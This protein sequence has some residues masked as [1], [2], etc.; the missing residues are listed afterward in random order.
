MKPAAP[1][2][3]QQPKFTKPEE[4]A[5]AKATIE[6]I[7]KVVRDPQ[8]APSPKAL[9]S[10]EVQKRLVEAVKDKLSGGQIT[11]YPDLSKLT[12]DKHECE[13]TDEPEGVSVLHT[14]KMDVRP[15]G[16]SVV[17]STISL[18]KP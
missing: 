3:A 4:V 2:P 9:Q 6:A 5:A 7:A 8:I 10:D 13:Q 11:L 15:K 18:R 12:D 16:A 17:S 1:A 14:G